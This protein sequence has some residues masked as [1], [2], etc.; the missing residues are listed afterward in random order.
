[1][2]DF[3]K[4]AEKAKR[5]AGKHP[6]KVN[7]GLDKAEK[8]AEEKTGGRF[9]SQIQQGEQKAEDFLGVVD[10]DQNKNQNK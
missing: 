7:Q 9:D 4:M 8:F 2:P 10:Q 5:F 1:M 6:D 3:R